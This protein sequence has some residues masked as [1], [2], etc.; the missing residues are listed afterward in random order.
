M[1]GRSQAGATP[2]VNV[3]DGLSPLTV[4]AKNEYGQYDPASLF[5]YGLDMVVEPFR[6]TTMSVTGGRSPVSLFHWR[7]AQ[8]SAEG[9]PLKGVDPVIDA[10]GGDQATVILNAPGSVFLLK[11]EER[12]IAGK[13]VASSAE[14]EVSCRYVRR[15]IRDLTDAD[16]EEFLEALKVYYTMGTEEGRAKY[17]HEFFNY[18]RITAFHSSPASSRS[19]ARHPRTERSISSRFGAE[20]SEE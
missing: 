1:G 5:L 3:A 2:S 19:F 15:E 14:V 7:L 8:L 12:D 10:L 20:G 16:R 17:G 13:A 18:E 4:V 11:V 6:E 9:I